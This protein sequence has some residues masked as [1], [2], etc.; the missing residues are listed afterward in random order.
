MR[1]GREGKRETARLGSRCILET[2][3]SGRLEILSFVRVVKG[4]HD[5]NVCLAYYIWEDHSE[6]RKGTISFMANNTE[7]ELTVTQGEAR[8]QKGNQLVVRCVN[9]R[10]RIIIWHQRAYPAICNYSSL[11]PDSPLLPQLPGIK[12]RQVAATFP[13]PVPFLTSSP[14]E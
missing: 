7:S 3:A 9:G 4:C 11:R 14:Q 12:G 5:F 1:H 2:A 6:R 10:G 8:G 13:L